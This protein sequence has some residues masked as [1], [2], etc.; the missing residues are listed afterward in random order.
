LLAKVENPEESP[1]VRARA[2]EALG[3]IASNKA[4][5]EALGNFG[6]K[7]IGQILIGLLPSVSEPVAPDKR[8]IGSIAVTALLRLKNPDHVNVTAAHRAPE[9]RE[10]GGRAANALARIGEGLSQ[11]VPA[12]I[13]ATGDREAIVRAHA[14]RALGV[15]RDGR[16]VEPLIKLL[17]DQDQ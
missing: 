8:L 6:V 15:A 1:L 13:A 12:L 11:A 2:A 9:S 5:A 10:W 17:S 14:A 4:S 7:A 3:K 16:A